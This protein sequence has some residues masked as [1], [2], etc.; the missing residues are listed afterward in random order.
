MK[1]LDTQ[2][3]KY[4]MPY[5]NVIPNRREVHIKNGARYRHYDHN[6]NYVVEVIDVIDTRVYFNV[7]GLDF[8]RNVTL[9]LYRHDNMLYVDEVITFSDEYNLIEP[10]YEYKFAIKTI[11]SVCSAEEGFV[12]EMSRHYYTLEEA[13]ENIN[14]EYKLLEFTKRERKCQ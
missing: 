3:E 14:A 7:N 8:P 13:P 2:G 11:C 5:D 12:W 4:S 10:V 6:V 1:H 9:V